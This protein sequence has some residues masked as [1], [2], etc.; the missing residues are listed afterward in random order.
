MLIAGTCT[1]AI[2]LVITIVVVGVAAADQNF[3]STRQ[4][5]FIYETRSGERA[6]IKCVESKIKKNK[7][8]NDGME[9]YRE[10]RR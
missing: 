2:V 8:Q 7:I 5:P 1:Q 6:L 9:E 10:Q 3:E 4:T